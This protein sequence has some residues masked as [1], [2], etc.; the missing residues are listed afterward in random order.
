[1][2]PALLKGKIALM[3]PTRIPRP[4]IR[5]AALFT[6]VGLGLAAAPAARA[7]LNIV[8]TY[9]SSITSDPN[10]AAMQQTIQKALDYY[11]NTVSS[12]ITLHITF[13]ADQT[14]SLGQ[15]NSSVI[16]VDYSAYVAALRRVSQGQP[17]LAFVPDTNPVNSSTK[18]EAKLA[19]L[20]LLG[21]SGPPD[22]PDSTVSFKTSI[23]NLSR[24]GTQDPNKND[25]LAVVEHEINEVLGI[26]SGLNGLNQTP[27]SFDPQGPVYGSDL[28][29][30]SAPGV[31]SYTTD[32]S[33][34]SYM[35]LDG[36]QTPIAYYNQAS[37][38]DFHDWYSASG[39]DPKYRG[40]VRVQDAYGGP[41]T[42]EDNGPA[43]LAALQ[44][45]GYT[46]AG[47]PSTAAPPLTAATVTGPMG[48]NGFYTGP[49]KVT[50]T[51]QAQ[52]SP[53][54]GTFFRLDGGAQQTYSGAFTVSGEGSHMLEE[55][56]TDAEGETEV[57]N[58]VEIKIDAFEPVTTASVAGRKNSLGGYLDAATVTLSA[59]D[60]LSGV[61]GTTYS[62]D[63]APAKPYT[64]P[65]TVSALGSHTVTFFSTDL[66]GNA[67]APKTLSVTVGPSVLNTF[68]AG[69]Q[70]ISV[71]EAYAAASQ[72][73]SPAPAKLASWDPALV[74]YTLSGPGDA[75]TPGRGYWAR[76]AQPTGLLNA[77]T[78]VRTSAPFAIPLVKGWNMVGDP[79][80]GPVA[81]SAV[82]VRD[83]AGKLYSIADANKAGLVY[84]VFYGYPAGSSQ[85]QIQ[86]APGGTLQPYQG[87]WARALQDCTLLVPP[88]AQ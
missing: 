63:G 13:K 73:L 62:V 25:M 30:Y 59:T 88:P 69:L 83:G 33:A 35:S 16:T 42:Q 24:T 75:L 38:G 3:L 71:P 29:R 19:H 17:F 54:T 78:S 48:Q 50:L 43:E 65:L 14:I 51:A 79:F 20:R 60:D 76:F 31:R 32:A 18:I 55:D 66:A 26:S 87:Y 39:A 15:A 52:R 10:G 57:P 6:L 74:N 2:G 22:G 47:T 7:Q 1:M 34:V 28:F 12:P 81:L 46:L 5:G 53:V 68:A 45:I 8:P 85:Y 40:P 4:R 36:G 77:G 86:R 67:E 11:R 23:M 9:D 72:G 41:G 84:T 58:D 64:A 44:V 82:Q 56:S 49:V 80:F 27:P 37:G 21:L 61:E 70:M